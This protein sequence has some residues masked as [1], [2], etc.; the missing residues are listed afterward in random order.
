MR[1]LSFVLLLP[2]ALGGC[3]M[4]SSSPPPRNTTVIVPVQ[5]GQAV[6]AVCANG[7]AP[8]C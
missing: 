4:F 5:P 3:L 2:V 8:P 7:S 1:L 6:Q